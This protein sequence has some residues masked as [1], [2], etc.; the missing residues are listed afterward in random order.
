V[1]QVPRVVL[2]HCV[3]RTLLRHLSVAGATTIGAFGWAATD[4]GPLLDLLPP[5]CDVFVTTDKNLPLQQRLDDRPFATIILVAK[6]NH[7]ADLLPLVDDLR[8]TVA[9]VRAGRVTR[10]AR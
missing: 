3:R 1:R 9:V 8:I 5:V 6:S 7:L 4:D 2:D 10:L